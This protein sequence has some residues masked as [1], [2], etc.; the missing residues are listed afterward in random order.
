M[1]RQDGEEILIMD[2]LE[3]L[4]QQVVIL[5]E[6]LSAAYLHIVRQEEFIATAQKYVAELEGVIKGEPVTHEPPDAYV[7]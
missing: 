1:E 5:E 4:R 7:N 3:R 6:M 2:D